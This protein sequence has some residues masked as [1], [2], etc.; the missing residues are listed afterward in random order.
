MTYIPK[1]YPP[2]GSKE[3]LADYISDFFGECGEDYKPEDVADVI[4]EGLDSWI[5]YHEKQAN[6]YELIRESLRK[7]V[8]KA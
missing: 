7:R 6:A 4:V 3:R 5:D 1:P 8:R 2:F